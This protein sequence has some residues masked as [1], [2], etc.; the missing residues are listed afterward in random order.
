MTVLRVSGFGGIIPRL[1][2][3][4][5]PDNNAQYAV[6]SQLYSGEL[7]AWAMPKLL[8]TF[9]MPAPQDVYHYRTDGVDHYVPFDRKTDVVKA[10]IINDAYGRLYLTDGTG[11]YITT[12]SD[13]EAAIPPVLAG[14]PEPVFGT[15]PTVVAS[16]G[17]PALAE[18]RVYV[19][20][21]VSKYGEEGPPSV[22]STITAA[23]NSDGAWTIGNISTLVP[24]G[25]NV[26]KLRVYRTITSAVSGVAYRQVVEWNVG[27]IPA[28][29][30]DNVPAT[31][32]AVAPI[33][34]SIDWQPPPL[35]LSGLC[36]GPGGMLAAF[37]GSTVYFSVPFFPHAW[38]QTYQLAVEDDIVAMG[39]V[40]TMLVIG[41]TGRPAVIQGNSPT[42]LSLQKFQEVFPCMS[43]RSLVSTSAAVI[44]ASLDGLLAFSP[45]GVNNTTNAFAARKDWIERFSPASVSGAV[46]Q[47]RYFGFYSTQLGFSLGFDDATTG[48][49]DLQYNGVTVM[50]NSAVDNSA[51]FIV[52]NK[53]FQ[54]DGSPDA[55]LFYSWRTKPFMVP[56]PCNMGVLQVRADFPIGQG[57]DTVAPPVVDPSGYAGN[58]NAINTVPINGIGGVPTS[59]S[60]NTV[61][62]K[63][64]ADDKL[65]WTG[66]VGSEAPIKMPSGF[67]GTKWEVEV[68]GSISV[69]SIVLAGTAKELEQVP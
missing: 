33:M 35:G 16:G 45:D 64:Y 36:A 41:T 43:A 52:G 20:I 21:L 40:G 8:T 67:K 37:K 60:S 15:K 55:T 2:K 66:S 51:Q 11:M 50:K 9:T 44:F 56:K 48:L 42:T 53:L 61:S 34:Q 46:Y 31:T 13:I 23:G 65:R 17:T 59:Q 10:P 62:V 25:G 6:N 57:N 54:W 32:V 4:L 68:S 3:R 30:V 7:R 38:P 12:R 49:T 58:E 26:A 27:A 24:P 19:F 29:Y 47:N 63:V 14:V 1:G 18:T 69:F 28:S 22:D 39:W 5:L